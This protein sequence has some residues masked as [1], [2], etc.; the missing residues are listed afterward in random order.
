MNAPAPRSIGYYAAAHWFQGAVL[1]V[2]VGALAIGLLSA[3]SYARESAEKLVVELTLR[4]MRTGMQLAMGETLMQQREREMATWAGRNPIA[5]LG[6][7]PDGYVGA[8]PL[9]GRQ[10]LPG[11]AWCFDDQRRELVYQPRH[12]KHLRALPEG[13]GQ[14]CGQLSWRVTRAP[15]SAASGGLVGLRLEAAS[16]CQWLVGG[17]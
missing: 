14:G 2:L 5:W 13:S 8:C 17:R 12:S 11:G 3:L 1:F 9:A 15:E 7:N 16:L 10:F 6:S 4:N